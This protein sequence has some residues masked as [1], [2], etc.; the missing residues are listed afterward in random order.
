M[1]GN[2]WQSIL[3]QS[4]SN[5]NHFKNETEYMIDSIMNLIDS[6]SILTIKKFCL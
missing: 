4:Y 5:H 6:I 3:I 2:H 1:I